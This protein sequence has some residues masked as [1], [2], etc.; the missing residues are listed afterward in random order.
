MLYNGDV[1]ATWHIELIWEYFS[2]LTDSGA[3]AK[4]VYEVACIGS[5][6][7]DA[8]VARRRS[9]MQDLMKANPLNM[10]SIYYEGLHL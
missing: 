10:F 5:D 9:E 3:F 7:E 4:P 6:L 2:S 8:S 1:S